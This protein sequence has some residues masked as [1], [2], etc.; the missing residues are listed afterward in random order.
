MPRLF[1]DLFEKAMWYVV[2]IGIEKKVSNGDD[3]ELQ[4]EKDFISVKAS[5]RLIAINEVKKLVDDWKNTYE[6]ETAYIVGAK[7]KH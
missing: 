5:N 7:A 4:F 1:Q 2:E 6:N 3:F